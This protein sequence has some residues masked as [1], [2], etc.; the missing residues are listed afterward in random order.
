MDKSKTSEYV[1]YRLLSNFFFNIYKLI[2]RF[3]N[4]FLRL[5][6]KINFEEYKLKFGEREDDIYIVT[7]PKSGTT[8]MQMILYHLTT[9][10]N[11]SFNHIYDVSPWIKNASFKRQEPIELPSPRIIK[12]H[13][14]YKDFP[15]STKGRFI[16]VYRDGMDVAVS[17]YH[18]QKNYNRSNL[19]FENFL[20]T[21][22]KNKSW[23]KHTKDW[24][25]NKKGFPIL[26]V[27]YENLINHKEEE[28]NKIVKFCEITPTKES[29]ERALKYSS[30]SYMKKNEEKF[31]DQPEKSKKIFDQFIRK[32]KSGEGTRYFT[33]DQKEKFIKQYEKMVKKP[34][35][36][37]FEKEALI[38][39]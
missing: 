21:F 8:L 37:A 17:H 30:F 1:G 28:I 35:T 10:G 36:R 32:G 39:H 9:E 18:Q 29:I 20:R 2:S 33:E 4:W 25:R 11:M 23:F 34:E 13:D 6:Q 27:R 14:F 19:E 31:G 26:Y 15:K 38:N 7:Y 16:Y 22:F 12:S 5:S 24:L 3:S